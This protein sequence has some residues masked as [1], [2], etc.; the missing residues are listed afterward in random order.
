MAR[1]LRLPEETRRLVGDLLREGLPKAEV[2]RRLGISKPTVTYH[3][4]PLGMPIEAPRR[5]DWAAVQA[6]Y[7]LGH[8]ISE[9]QRRFGFA[10][11]SF[12]A[13]VRR[14]EI[15]SRPQAMPITQLLSTRTRNRT[16]V[17][18]RLLR[19]GLLENRC[20]KCGLT[21]WQ[22]APIPL[23]LHHVNGDGRDNR[24]ENLT[25]LCPNCHAQTG[26]WGG[27]NRKE[28][29]RGLKAA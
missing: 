13:A 21:E 4:A 3:A 29:A 15:V 22:G 28:V 1:P 20:A 11:C 19:A 18:A 24:L 9:C 7:D 23:E 8:S 6:Y 17:K 2:A 26:S 14:G 27:R 5:Y 12:T 16:H 10:R 25:I